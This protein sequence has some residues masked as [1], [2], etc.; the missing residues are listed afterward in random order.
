MWLEGEC[1]LK[2][3]GCGVAVCAYRRV[4]LCAP[5]VRIEQV[6][7]QVDDLGALGT[8][9][10]QGRVALAVTGALQTKGTGEAMHGQVGGR[11]NGVRGGGRTWKPLPCSMSSSIDST[12]SAISRSDVALP[13]ALLTARRPN[14]TSN[15][16]QKLDK[17]IDDLA[18]STCFNKNIAC[19]VHDGLV[20]RR[21]LGVGDDVGLGATLQE[22][23]HDLG[24]AGL[25]GQVKRRLANQALR[26]HLHTLVPAHDTK[27]RR[28]LDV[29]YVRDALGHM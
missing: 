14:Q 6:G 5:A 10:V 24:H 1:G 25:H 2:E 27:A 3:E 20:E 4:V 26:V 28:A 11:E 23:L 13:R 17:V 22:E 15:K 16:V 18:M 21:L 7:E 19:H 29:R 9:K 12:A 8:G